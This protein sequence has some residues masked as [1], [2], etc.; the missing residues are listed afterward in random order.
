MQYSCHILNLCLN[1]KNLRMRHGT[2]I[3]RMDYKTPA[4]WCNRDTAKVEGFRKVESKGI[5]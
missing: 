4:I 3:V 5:Y 1:V 2:K